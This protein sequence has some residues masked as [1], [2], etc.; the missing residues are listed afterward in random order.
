MTFQLKCCLLWWLR[1]LKTY[2]CRPIPSSLKHIP[3]VISY[4]DGEGKHA[5]VGAAVWAPWLRRPLAVY[6]KVSDHLRAIWAVS[7]NTSEYNDI[8]PIEAIGPLLLLTAFPNVMKNVLWIHWIDNTAAEASLISGTS[9]LAIADHVVGL[10]WELCGQR[11]VWPY[12]DRV[13]SKSNPVDQLSR[14]VMEG[15]WETVVNVDLPYKKLE[16]LAEEC[17]GWHSKA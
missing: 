3:V 4:S 17:G 16:Q 11:K 12:F 6:T 8:F 5:G 7:S 2:D 15:P 13:E 14:G 9:S 1:F 10:T